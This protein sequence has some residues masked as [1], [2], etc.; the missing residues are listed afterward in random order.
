MRNKFAE[1]FLK[2]AEKNDKLCAVV[3]DISP[4]GAMDEFRKKYPNRFINTGVA[5]E[6]FV[7]KDN[8]K[9][10]AKNNF[11]LFFILKRGS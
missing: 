11:F 5:Y 4:A 10:V 2:M 1:T 9:T 3:A 7:T 6:V 8:N